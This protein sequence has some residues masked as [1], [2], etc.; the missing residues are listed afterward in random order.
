MPHSGGKRDAASARTC[1][2]V[3]RARTASRVNFLTRSE[4]I[5][6]PQR[7]V[8]PIDTAP[9]AS[10]RGVAQPGSA[11][12]WGACGRRF[13]SGRPDF[14]DDLANP[15]GAP[16]APGARERR[17]AVRGSTSRAPDARPVRPSG[18]IILVCNDDGIRSAGIQALAGVLEPLGDV[19][20]VAPDREQSAVSHALTLHRPLRVEQEG[21]R[22]FT[23]DGTPTDCVNLAVSGILPG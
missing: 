16:C 12:A 17:P 8:V 15:P 7:R 10:F 23:V 20:V 11:H 18:M 19:W 5:G 21:N 3:P 1:P 14:A 2:R 4:L 22:Q 9:S 13:K 6:A